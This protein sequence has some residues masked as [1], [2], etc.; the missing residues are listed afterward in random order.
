MAVHSV[1][2]LLLEALDLLR[3][4]GSGPNQPSEPARLYRITYPDWV[5]V[6]QREGGI[7][8]LVAGHWEVAED[9]ALAAAWV[10]VP[11]H[12]ASQPPVAHLG[13]AQLA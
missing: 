12:L 9:L 2:P 8:L 5:V 1:P 11:R 13:R 3:T 7:P 10:Q 4:Q 6:E